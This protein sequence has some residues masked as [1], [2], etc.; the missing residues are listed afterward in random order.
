MRNEQDHEEEVRERGQR[1]GSR[2]QL[3]QSSCHDS[4][5]YTVLSNS[6]VARLPLCLSDKGKVGLGLV[7]PQQLL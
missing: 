5:G 4:L 6:T 7:C 3:E 1:V 2:A